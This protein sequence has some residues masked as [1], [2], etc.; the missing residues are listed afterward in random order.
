MCCM[1][2]C[3]HVHGILCVFI[4]VSGACVAHVCDKLCGSC[5]CVHVC[6]C[7]VHMCVVMCVWCMCMKAKGQP[8]VS[9]PGAVN[10]LAGLELT[11]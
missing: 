7:V 1:C 6:M 9:S 2:V 8:V 10:L 4:C 11:K 3:V 5:M